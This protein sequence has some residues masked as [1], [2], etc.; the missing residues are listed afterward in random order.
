MQKKGLTAWEDYKNAIRVCRDEM[1]KAKASL[2]LKLARDIMVNRK[3]FFKY[4]EGKRKTRENVGPL[5][6]ETGAMVIE[7]AEDAAQTSPQ[8]SQT[9]EVTEK[10]WMKKDFH[11]VE[12]DQ[13]RDKLIKLDIH[14]SMAPDGMHL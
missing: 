11:L 5:L 10:A 3:G 2:V 8:E 7:K 9:L 4:I 6:N 1:R 13:V 14:N 12:E